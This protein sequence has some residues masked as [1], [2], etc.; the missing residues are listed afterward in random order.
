M[1][2]KNTNSHKNTT[3]LNLKTPSTAENILTKLEKFDYFP[4]II[5]TIILLVINLIYHKVGDYGVETDFFWMYVPE[6][7]KI[8]SGTLPID[9]FR[10]PFYPIMLAI[11]KLF[12][13]DFFKAGI[14]L[15]TVAAGISLYFLDKTYISLILQQRYL[16]ILYS[17]DLFSYLQFLLTLP[18]KCYFYHQQKYLL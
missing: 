11:F 12:I 8:L 5:Y 1:A 14:V 2:K 7:K 10:G 3:N 6:A 18:L 9:Q 16:L 13:G 17:P 4:F 15:N